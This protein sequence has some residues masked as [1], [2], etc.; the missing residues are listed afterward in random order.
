MLITVIN[1]L[2]VSVMIYFAVSK[3]IDRTVVHSKLSAILILDSIDDPY[4]IRSLLPGI[5]GW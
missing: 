5:W 4:I 2:A 1:L 3:G